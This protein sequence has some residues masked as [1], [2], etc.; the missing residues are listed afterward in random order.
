M[1]RENPGNP[2]SIMQQRFGRDCLIALA[3]VRE[4]KPQVRAVNAYYQ[5]G[6]FYV[7]T[8][9]SSKKMRDI[10]ADPSIAIAGDWFTAQGRGEDLGEFRSEQN[11]PLAGKLKTV[12]A[13]W[14][15]NG[16]SDLESPDT[17]ILRLRLERGLL[18]SNGHRI[19][20]TF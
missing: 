2:Q 4:G 20:L 5:D 6:A 10:A 14:I 12:F 9:A 7:V 19:E 11:A 18:L 15:G 13:A 16:H 8:N 17:H 3:T 1:S